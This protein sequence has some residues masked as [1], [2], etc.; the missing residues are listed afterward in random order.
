MGLSAPWRMRLGWGMEGL[1]P[2]HTRAVEPT[3][4][5][6]LSGNDHGVN[7]EAV[8]TGNDCGVLPRGLSIQRRGHV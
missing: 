5:A 7:S 2:N 8:P 6:V 3:P 1:G 4:S